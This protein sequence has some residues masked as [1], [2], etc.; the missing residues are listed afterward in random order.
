M[1]LPPSD[2]VDNMPAELDKIETGAAEDADADA[3]NDDGG[4]TRCP[5]EEGLGM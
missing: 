5:C 2:S 4:I 1:A 3:M